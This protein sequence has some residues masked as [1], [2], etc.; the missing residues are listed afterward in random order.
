MLPMSMNQL[1]S[2]KLTS[3]NSN[4]NIVVVIITEI[5]F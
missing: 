5:T 2:I 1:E 4:N 3:N